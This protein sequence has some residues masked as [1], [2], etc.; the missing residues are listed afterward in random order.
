MGGLGTALGLSGPPN[1]PIELLNP[2]LL[3]LRAE[4]CSLWVNALW[5]E[6]ER[7]SALRIVGRKALGLGIVV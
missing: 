2:V 7:S 5:I 6:Y 4:D 3:K 1:Y